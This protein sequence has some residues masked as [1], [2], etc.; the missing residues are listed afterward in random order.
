MLLKKG[1]KKD[2]MYKNKHNQTYTKKHQEYNNRNS[3]I[4]KI[5]VLS[6]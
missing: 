6:V 3:R 4:A 5:R 2:I 1:E